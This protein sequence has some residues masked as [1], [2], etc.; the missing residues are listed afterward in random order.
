MPD[1]V[2]PG[3]SISSASKF[4]HLEQQLSVKCVFVHT[5]LRV[6][7]RSTVKA[8]MLLARQVLVVVRVVFAAR[9]V[10]AGSPADARGTELFLSPRGCSLVR[11]SGTAD[12]HV[13]R[14]A[15]GRAVRRTADGQHGHA[16]AQTYIDTHIVRETMFL[17]SDEPRPCS[18]RWA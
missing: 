2:L 18:D 4:C 9:S 15:P 6:I 10:A 12:A 1:I 17:Q 5:Q 16:A 14:L 7:D 3:L 8:R 13:Q 11:A